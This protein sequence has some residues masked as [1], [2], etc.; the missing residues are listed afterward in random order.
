MSNDNFVELRNKQL[1]EKLVKNLEKRH[2]EAFF[3]QTKEE[4]MAI[5]LNLIPKEESV[6]WGGSKTVVD[7]G[8]IDYLINNNYKVINRDLA[9]DAEEKYLLLTQALT[10]FTYLTGTN[11]ITVDGELVNVDCIGN[12]VS[13]LMFGPKNV[14]VIIG[15]NKISKDL[16]EAVSR[17]RNYAAP[18]N[19]QRIS[20]VSGKKTP[21]LTDGVCHNCLS[22]DSICSNIVI[23]RL[24]NPLGR[25]K[26]ILVNENLGF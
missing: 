22:S 10:S 1:G 21:C 14:V 23:T 11:A 7:T 9:K 16:D 13:A 25:I 24:C 19:M 17:A 20:A 26:V 2:F 8:L 15:V 4:A 6:S 18:V 3:A 5:A 12:R